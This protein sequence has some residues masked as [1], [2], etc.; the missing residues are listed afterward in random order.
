MSA[1]EICEKTPLIEKIM[2]HFGWYKVQKVEMQVENIE[3]NHTFIIKDPTPKVPVKKPAV[4]KVARRTPRS[5]F[6]FEKDVKNG[7]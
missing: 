2:A 3:I 5:D 4:K 7:N 1:I 6:K